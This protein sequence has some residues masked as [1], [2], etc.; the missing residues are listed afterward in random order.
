MHACCTESWLYRWERDCRTMATLII[1]CGLSM[2][3]SIIIMPLVIAVKV[4]CIHMRDAFSYGF[5]EWKPAQLPLKMTSTHERRRREMW[6]RRCVASCITFVRKFISLCN[7][8][9]RC[10]RCPCRLRLYVYGAKRTQLQLCK[11]GEHAHSEHIRRWIMM[12]QPPT[13]TIRVEENDIKKS[14]VNV[15]VCS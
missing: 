5:W 4:I 7:M 2:H 9:H 10:H 3:N 12:R 8:A 6:E 1:W 14:L 13:C 15:C 11:N